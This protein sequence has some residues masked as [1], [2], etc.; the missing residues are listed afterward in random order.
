MKGDSEEFLPKTVQS[1]QQQAS[2]NLMQLE[3][4]LTMALPYHYLLKFCNAIHKWLMTY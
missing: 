2:V 4:L 3:N 1:K